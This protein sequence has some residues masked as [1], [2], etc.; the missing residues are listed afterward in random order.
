MLAVT[1]DYLG[2][3]DSCL[4]MLSAFVVIVLTVYTLVVH[5]VKFTALA[6]SC[7]KLRFLKGNIY[8][9][10]NIISSFG[11]LWLRGRAVSTAV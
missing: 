6:A 4:N 9:L 10:N 5:T 11:L 1:Q 3:V 8:V 7:L 2:I